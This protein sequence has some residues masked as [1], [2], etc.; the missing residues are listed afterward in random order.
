[1]GY[2]TWR[3]T[4]SDYCTDVIQNPRSVAYSTRNRYRALVEIRTAAGPSSAVQCVLSGGPYTVASQV[5][6]CQL[7]CPPPPCP[8]QATC[9]TRTW[10][11]PSAWPFEHPNI[12]A[13]NT[14]GPPPRRVTGRAVTE[15]SAE[16]GRFSRTS[17]RTR[18]AYESGTGSGHW[19][20]RPESDSVPVA[21]RWRCRSRTRIS[22]Q[23]EGAGIR[24]PAAG[25]ALYSPI[26]AGHQSAAA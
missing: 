25:V 22:I 21:P 16:V 1:M 14:L 19:I 4:R 10:L 3:G 6:Q 15:V 7:V 23:D 8:R 5:R 2:C 11:G 9:P 13:D 20:R 26:E 24:R 12:N 18:R 17:T